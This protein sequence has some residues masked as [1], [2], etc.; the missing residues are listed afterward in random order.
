MADPIDIVIPILRGIQ[1]DVSEMK[2]TLQKLDTLEKDV[3]TLR[4]RVI[5]IM[6][7]DAERAAALDDHETEIEA[8]K[9]RLDA[10]ERSGA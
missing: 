10:L 6:G 4:N 5:A 8:I 2:V 3:R 7:V 1:S 9:R